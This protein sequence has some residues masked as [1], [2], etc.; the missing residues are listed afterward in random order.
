MR[1][2]QILSLAALLSACGG[3]PHP[4]GTVEGKALVPEVVSARD[5][6]RTS[7][8]REVNASS[9][10]Q[11]LFGDLHVHSTYSVDAFTLELPM[12]GLQGIHTVADACDFARY[13]GKLDFFSYNDHAEGL[14]PKF[15]QDTKDTIRACNASSASVNPDLVAF[16]GWEWTQMRNDANAHFGH[17]NVIFP[18]T[19]DDELPPRPI[20]ARITPDDLGVFAM[21]RNS[22]SGRY[23]D[24]LN[25]KA[26][27]NLI[28]LL[29]DI[30]EVPGCP[31]DVNSRELPAD[32]HENA[33]TPDV[34]YRK[35]DEW[36]FEHMI[37]PHGN[38][39]GAYTP[40]TAT[41]DKA[42][43]TRYHSDQRQPL[44][45]VMSGHGNSEEYRL[46]HQAIE[47]ADGSLSCPE[48]QGD[49]I[50]CCWQ[51]GEIMRQRCD[52]LSETECESRVELSR[53]YAVEAGNRYLGVFPD[54][55]ATDWGRCNQCPDCFKPAFNQ[56]FAE[57][58]QYAMALT[59]FDET[60]EQGRPLRFRWGFIASTD[61]H[62][63]RPGTGYKQ[64]QRRMM[65]QASGVRSDFYGGLMQGLVGEVEDPQMPK[66]IQTT[67]PIPDLARM[68]S[69]LYPGGIVAVHAD[70]R[71][72]RDIWAA[73]ARKEVYGTSGPRMLL[74]FDL[75][76]S[77]D[78]TLPMGSGAELAENPQFEV[79][80]VGAWK[81]KPGCPADVSDLGSERLD[82]LCAGECFNP[83]DERELI[84]AI[85]VVRIRPQAF[86]GESIEKLIED[87][88]R[89][90]KCPGDPAG[91]VVQFEDPDYVADGRDTVYYVRA[92]QAP[93]PAINADNLRPQLDSQGEVESLDPC[94]GDYRTDFDDDCL[95]PAQERAWSSPI[96][97]DQPRRIN[98]AIPGTGVPQ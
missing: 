17:K 24:P 95:A 36:G 68:N 75:V 30:A 1:R 7:A 51:A 64:Y 9:D 22:G 61:D 54:S 5:A 71:D 98:Q 85:E 50:P 26:Y 70:S 78:G 20:S 45:E 32:C 94:Y 67:T 55:T 27:A 91:C 89:R 8:A 40:P 52:G 2:L 25:W 88:W 16:A 96:F 77:P 47:N 92:L 23:V 48:P 4:A 10:K 56:V 90:F 84:S 35:L 33:P 57:S 80:A 60:D 76:N 38:T 41:W 46:F 43:A 14:T 12:M 59:N 65:T 97:V 39:W 34:L 69:F 73:M 44:L 21:S 53:Q 15:W 81:Q 28:R 83:S 49:F 74:W 66:R 29:D 13:C 58:S 19:A 79:R 86:P 37:I 31:T 62:T 18:G 42:L 63:S 3:D 82:Y 6:G 93:T 11:I 72:R 87:P